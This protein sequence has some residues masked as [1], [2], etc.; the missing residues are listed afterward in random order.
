VKPARENQFVKPARE[1]G[2]AIGFIAG[3]PQVVKGR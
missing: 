1:A 3:K 2:L